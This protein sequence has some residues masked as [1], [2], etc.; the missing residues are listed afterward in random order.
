M[1]DKLRITDNV[2]AI[3]ST[4]LER[5][6]K[7]W[8]GLEIAKAAGIGN[9]TIYAALT[10]MKRSGMV[11]AGWETLGPSELGRPQRR[12]YSL[13]AEGARVGTEALA[14]YRPRVRLSRDWPGWLPGPE[15]SKGTT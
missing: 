7:S 6:R 12:L 13:T 2:V 1:A 11:R 4:M 9:A 14:N 8:Y 15:T 3:F 10:R 5:P